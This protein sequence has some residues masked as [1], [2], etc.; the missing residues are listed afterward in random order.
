MF[1]PRLYY[2]YTVFKEIVGILDILIFYIQKMSCD[3]PTIF[4]WGVFSKN[5]SLKQN[6]FVTVSVK[7]GCILLNPSF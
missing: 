5:D 1:S 2:N 6:I 7:L 3:I 4:F